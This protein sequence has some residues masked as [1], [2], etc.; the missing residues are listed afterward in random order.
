MQN[1]IFVHHLD[2]KNSVPA[3]S[4]VNDDGTYSIFLNSRL[5][6]EQQSNGYM[7]ELKHI[8]QLDFE[9]RE[10]DIS[11]LEHYAHKVS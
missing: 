8:L 9:N 11:L 10:K 4:T 2:F 6:Q 7:H 5:N 1:E 3:T